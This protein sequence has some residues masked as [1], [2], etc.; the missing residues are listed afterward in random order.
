MRHKV[1]AL[2][3]ALLL[4]PVFADAE[5]QARSYGEMFADSTLRI[6]FTF[7]GS[8]YSH[9]APTIA[10]SSLTKYSGWGGRRVNLD[11]TLREGTADVTLTTM[12]GDTIY[13]NP[14]CTLFQEW[15]VS[16][17]YSGPKAMEGT[18]L[19][20]FPRDSVNVTI[21]LRNNRRTTVSRAT[22]RV[23]PDDILIADH[24]SRVPLPHT[25]VYRGEYPDSAKIC[26]AILA[27]GYTE[28][29]M[30]LFHQRA[31]EAVDAIFDH[32]P[33]ASMADRFDFIAVET[34]N[35]GSGVSVPAQ[36]VWTDSA[37]GSHFSTFYSDR[38]L[39][40][41]N[42]HDLYDAIEATHA[43]HLIVLA[44]T[45]EYGGGG[46]FN[47][48]T[49]TAADNKMFR[50][51]VVHEFGHSFAGLADEYYYDNDIMDGTYPLDIE[52][53]EP[54][55][56]TKTD[57]AAKWHRLVDEG[58]ADLVEGAGYRA[59]GIWRGSHD[60]RMRTN[61]APEFCPV[62]QSAIRDIILWYTENAVSDKH[63]PD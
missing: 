8:C 7:S 50:E 17:D 10:F 28:A 4:A 43:G 54:N 53:W 44:N 27:E 37:F 58:K 52:P 41:S 46:I 12:T 47:F 26:V 20:P 42:V 16:E 35:A 31:R 36:G 23:T 48:Y 1:I 19:V 55:I 29:E 38:Y 49:L 57:F 25:Y 9:I 33:F 11:S 24:T 32:E 56:T 60:C 14:F 34:P 5:A 61:T 18:V 63:F 45:E 6:D 40:T 22:L 15:L 39:T 13:R 59:N 2:L 3:A 51:V 21:S 62:C 30:P